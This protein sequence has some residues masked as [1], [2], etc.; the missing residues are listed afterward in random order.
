MRADLFY[1][2]CQAMEDIS[3]LEIE[4]RVLTIKENGVASH[5]K[6]RL[7]SYNTYYAWWTSLFGQVL[8]SPAHFLKEKLKRLE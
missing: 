5:F 3:T 2:V 1:I 8:T 7:A 6:C 4:M